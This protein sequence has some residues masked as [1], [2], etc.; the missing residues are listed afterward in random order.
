MPSSINNPKHWRARAHEMRTLAALADDLDA[1]ASLLTV[2]D[3]YE[4]LARRAE[5]RSSGQRRASDKGESRPD[6]QRSGGC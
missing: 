2:A 6:H 4:K 5:Q 3:E 1:R